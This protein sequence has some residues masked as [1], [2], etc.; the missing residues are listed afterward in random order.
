MKA[1][2]IG[3]LMLVAG[4]SSSNIT[5]PTGWKIK[6]DNNAMTKSFDIADVKIDPNG[7]V[8]L[9]FENYKSDPQAALDFTGNLIKAGVVTAGVTMVP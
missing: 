2:I 4:C 6:L 1:M 5:T 7:L 9:R 3:V 8:H